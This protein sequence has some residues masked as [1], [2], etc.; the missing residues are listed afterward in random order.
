MD[1]AAVMSGTG[2]SYMQSGGLY[3]PQPRILVHPKGAGA[4]SHD[5][6][7]VGWMQQSE[8]EALAERA[9]EIW[10]F[11]YKRANSS[12]PQPHTGY[13]YDARRGWR[14]PSD[15][16]NNV[17]PNGRSYSGGGHNTRQGAAPLQRQTE[18]RV[19]K[20]E[21]YDATFDASV[22]FLDSNAKPHTWPIAPIATASANDI[23]RLGAS[24]Q[25]KNV[26]AGGRSGTVK[27]FYS[28]TFTPCT[29]SQRFAFAFAVRDDN[30]PRNRIIGPMSEVIRADIFPRI[31]VQY[32][33]PA[34]ADRGRKVRL[35]LG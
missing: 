28:D 19:T 16:L 32:D 35:R 24:G 7:S 27:S 21:F 22:W 5:L 34:F 15:T 8:F 25:K 26:S 31:K 10:L 18:W 12:V 14:H 30:D 23:D 4:G 3:I 33:C 13:R 1:G 2:G 17:N 9:P 29:Q 11:R 20:S 6:V